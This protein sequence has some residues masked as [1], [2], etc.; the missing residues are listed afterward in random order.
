LCTS[1]VH[2]VL[3]SLKLCIFLH[4]FPLGFLRLYNLNRPLSLSASSFF[5]LW[6]SVMQ[7]LMTISGQRLRFS[8]VFHPVHTSCPQ[9]HFTYRVPQCQECKS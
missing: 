3:H 1:A 4:S 2:G 8:V 5:C 7:P 6:K 9:L